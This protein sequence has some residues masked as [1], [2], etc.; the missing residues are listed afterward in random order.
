VGRAGP[1]LEPGGHFGATCS[2]YGRRLIEAE[3][4]ITGRSDHSG[5][6]NASP[7]IHHRYFPTIEADGADSLHELVTMQGYDAEVSPA[8]TGDVD[9]RVFES[10]VEELNRLAP[11][12]M[13]AGYW[14]SVSASWNGGT[15][16]A[17]LRP[18]R[19]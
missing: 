15:T 3:F 9:L 14:R 19:E 7:M 6:V 13:I 17:D 2:A 8:F 1:R 5:F 11:K 12:E 18:E 16:L 10:P 4:T